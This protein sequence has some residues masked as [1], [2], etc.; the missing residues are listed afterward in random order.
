[1]CLESIS[2][3]ARESALIWHKNHGAVQRKVNA[4]NMLIQGQFFKVCRVK[5]GLV[6]EP[7]EVLETTLNLA[8]DD[9]PKPHVTVDQAERRNLEARQTDI[10]ASGGRGLRF[11]ASPRCFS[12]GDDGLTATDDA[13]D[14]RW[15]GTRE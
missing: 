11:S 3:Y 1:M 9:S 6:F 15:L 10:V 14:D 7:F 4:A 5:K 8:C 2:E 13:K 12:L